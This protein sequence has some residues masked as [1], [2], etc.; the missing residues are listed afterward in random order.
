MTKNSAVR[1][2]A[3]LAAALAI[4]AHADE[5]AKEIDTAGWQT[6]E[7][8]HGTGCAT[9][10]SPYEFYVHPGDPKRIALYFEGGGGCWNSSNCG[11]DGQA[12]FD[13][14]VDDKDRPW[15]KGAGVGGILDAANPG[16][17][18]RDFTI[19]FA[20]YC[21]ADVHLGVDT[22]RYEA[23]EG[24]NLTVRYRGLANSQRV[25]DWVTQQYAD[26]K[27]VFVSGGSA[28]AIPSPIFASQLARQY[29]KAH[30]VQLG[31]GA[32][33]YRT[34]RLAQWLE[35]WG[36]TRALKHDPLYR[37]IDVETA[38]FEDFYSRAAPV[39]N[40]QL[41]Q[42]N[43][44]EDRTQ[45]FFLAQLGNQV[46]S[47]APLLSANIA[48]L[49]KADPKLRTYTMPGVVHTVLTRPDFYTAKVDDVALTK[50]LDDLVNGR[51]T[52]N[53]GDSLLVP[54]AERLQ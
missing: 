38:N 19:V 47:L 28:G 33:G 10:A 37:D 39:A 48:D 26:P 41:A 27:T 36:A 21:T 17:P 12:T 40:L 52:G 15:L 43:S 32:G 6:V 5:P 1:I 18:L 30:V 13:P 24:K 22:V 46:T 16:N 35:L 44:I 34:K 8:G 49:R 54:G 11:L 9:D 7:G 2:F 51:K 53:V 4:V 50:W 25:M 29:T 3:G 42:I 20:P 23:S 31:D 14:S 45:L